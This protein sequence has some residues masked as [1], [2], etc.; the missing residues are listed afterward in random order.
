MIVLLKET[1]FK[2]KISSYEVINLINFN[3]KRRL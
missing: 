2:N 1:R 3:D